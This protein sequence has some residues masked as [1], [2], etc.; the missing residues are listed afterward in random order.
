[1]ETLDPVSAE[2]VALAARRADLLIIKGGAPDVVGKL[3]PRAVWLWPSGES[4]ETVIPADWYALGRWRSPI[5]GS[6]VGMPVDSFPPLS[7]IT[8]IEPATAIGPDLQC[9]RAVGEPSARC[10][11]AASPAAP[12]EC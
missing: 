5:A 1:M 2:D 9:R 3:R 11:P 12:E 6:L 8:P 4:G 10:L 7:A